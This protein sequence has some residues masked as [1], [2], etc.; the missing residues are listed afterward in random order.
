M[1]DK[2]KVLENAG[3][4]QNWLLEGEIKPEEIY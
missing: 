3:I 4:F 1:I 2:K